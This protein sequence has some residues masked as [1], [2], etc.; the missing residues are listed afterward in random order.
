MQRNHR[1]IRPF[2][3]IRKKDGIAGCHVF[4]K[5]RHNKA[6]CH[7]DVLCS[8]RQKECVICRI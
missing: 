4:D 6:G 2:W 8:C 7:T 1:R 5:D 3:C